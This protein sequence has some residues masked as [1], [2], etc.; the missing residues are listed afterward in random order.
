MDEAALLQWAQAQM[1]Q[2]SSS[3]AAAAR[4]M[5]RS[6]RQDAILLY[7][8]CRHC[9]DMIDGQE[10]GGS[11]HEPPAEV[12]LMRL[13]ALIAETRA[14][15]EINNPVAP[16]YQALRLVAR[17]HDMPLDWPLDLIEGFRWDVERRPFNTIGDTLRYGY[18]VAGV[19]GV[20]MARLMG[21]RDEAVLDRACDLG[22][23]FQL[24]NIA[25]DVRED[26]Q[27]GRVYLPAEWLGGAEVDP[28]GL[29]S[30]NVM[31]ATLR[32]LDTAEPYYASARCGLAAL[33]A[34]CAWGIAAAHRIYREIGQQIRKQGAVAYAGRVSTS[35]SRKAVLLAAGLGD[36]GISRLPRASTS[37]DGLWTRPVRSVDRFAL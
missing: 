22:L 24:T 12:Q 37:R 27:A 9:D 30:P 19:V 26:A 3:F 31:A 5:P 33:P 18:H 10:L 35:R 14:A 16:P 25:R 23:A 7:A 29:P 6:A 17:R 21:V 34:G 32:L 28:E 15:L 13:E 8:W 20:M 36:M 11:L 4:V 1:A 2:G